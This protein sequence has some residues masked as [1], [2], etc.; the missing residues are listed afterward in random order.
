MTLSL[1]NRTRRQLRVVLPPGIIAQSATG[2][3]GG[4]GGMGGGMMGGMGGGMMG[5]MG[6][7]MMGGMG[8][9]MMGG[10]GG[11]M[12]GG[13]GGGGMGGMGSMG[14]S[15]GTMPA[16]MGHDDAFSHDHV[17]LRRSRKLGYA[18]PDDRHDGRRHG[19]HGRRNDGRNGRR[20][21]RDGRWNAIRPAHGP[22]DRAAQARSSAAL[23]DAVGERLAAG[24]PAGTG[25]ARKGEKLRIVGDIAQVNDN[26]QVSKAL[27]RLAADKAP[28]A[29]A[30][31]VM[32]RLV[33]GLDWES[34]ADLSKKWSNDYELTLARDFVERL[35]SLT[36]SETGRLQI[37][38]RGNDEASEPMAAEAVEV[39]T[40]KTVLGLPAE[41]GVPERPDG[42]TVAAGCALARA[43]PMFRF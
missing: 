15:S 25:H 43:T 16:T 5:G 36:D 6:G 11:G 29:V 4:M 9:G 8:G 42:P 35:D 32:W 7:G 13:G 23:A 34:I 40:G 38:L 30:Q 1:T 28:A 14:M 2:Q 18:K 21:G 17:F 41:T 26:P 12:G 22:T 24:S 27:K 3:F 37:E 33:A 10:M 20:N 31:L 19:R 39:L